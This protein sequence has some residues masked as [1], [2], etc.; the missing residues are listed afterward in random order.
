MYKLISINGEISYD[1]KE[2][3]CDDIADLYELP[4]AAMG[5][6]CYVINT[7][8]MFILGGDKVWR[9]IQDAAVTTS[10]LGVAILESGE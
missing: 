4:A 8:Q 6:K 2:F 7:N 10:A 1:I 9:P 5:S 3:V